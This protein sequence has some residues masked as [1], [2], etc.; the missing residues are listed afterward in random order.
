M[1]EKVKPATPG[2]STSNDESSVRNNRLPDS[3]S[4]RRVLKAS[5][6][7]ALAAG[8]AGCETNGTPTGTD[9]DGETPTGT[10]V[11]EGTPDEVQKLPVL[12][13]NSRG[14][15]QNKATS[16]AQELGV[17]NEFRVNEYGVLQYINEES[18]MPIPS[19]DVEPRDDAGE[20][21]TQERDPSMAM[22][23]DALAE[24][25]EPP[26][27]DQLASEFVAALEETEPL[28]ASPLET[29]TSTSHA[30]I[31]IENAEDG[32]TE[33]ERPL[34]TAVYVLAS[35]NNVPLAGPGAKI[36]GRASTLENGQVWADVRHSFR[37]DVEPGTEVELLSQA[38]VRNRY[39]SA[40]EET[41]DAEV[42]ELAQPRLVYLAPELRRVNDNPVGD[43]P[44]QVQSLVPHYSVGGKVRVGEQDFELLREFLPATENSDYIPEPD[45]S[46]SADGN[47]VQA[48]VSIEGGQPPYKVEWSISKG[49]LPLDPSSDGHPP[50]FDER[51]TARRSIEETTLTVEVMDANGVNV[52]KRQ[53]LSVEVESSGNVSTAS[54]NVPGTIDVGLEATDFSSWADGYRTMALAS[55]VDVNNVWKN[56]SVWEKDFKD[57]T[58][59]SYGIDTAD[60]TYTVAHGNPMGFA[61]P[62]NC[63]DDRFVHH[64]D[65]DEAWGNNDLEWHSLM[66]CNVLAPD[67]GNCGGCNGKSR[68]QRWWQE[69]DRLHQL[70]GF[71]TLGWVVSGFPEALARW[72]FGGFFWSAK[73]MRTA[74]FLAVDN[75]QPGYDP[76]QAWKRRGVVMYTADENWRC[77][78]DDYFHGR[79]PVGP[80]IP[81]EDVRWICWI[82]AATGGG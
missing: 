72:V 49:I 67:D 57:T 59:N 46:A 24:M 82:V 52:S 76:D 78:K 61:I 8:L 63:C 26:N 11:D 19:A 31:E 41:F 37:Q 6:A 16:L 4:R 22:D 35:Y 39:R 1:T 23:V 68:V 48:S 77:G 14:I 66:S 15:S 69:F 20:D 7:A 27:A 71:Q 34:D 33:L 64:T 50:E 32:S 13:V 12:E 73:M 17:D 42:V 10:D 44:N 3:L 47:R 53:Q 75:Y 60:H 36:R 74:W 29:S 30:R 45:L 79:G 2:E 56:N 62:N 40:L 54:V 43:G 9:G 38:D 51:I 55:G 65:A 5:G 70:H 21:D 18:Y 80:D 58:D 28:P 81:H 25:P